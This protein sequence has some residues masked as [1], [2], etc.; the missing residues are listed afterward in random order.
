MAARG[1]EKAAIL[2]MSIGEQA[3]ADVLSFM[4]PKE[5][6]AIG[7][8]MAQMQNISRGQVA[9]ILNEFIT[10]LN[11]ETGLGLANDQYVRN[12][13]TKA[14]G[15]DKASSL[16]DRILHG[17]NTKG[18]ETLKWMD[19]RAVA[20]I[21]RQEHPQIIA[22]VLS[23]LESDQ[24]A[25]ILGLFPERDRVDILMRIASLESI[26]PAAMNELNNILEKQF[27]GKD[28]IMS[29]HVGGKKTAASILNFMD[30]SMEAETMDG[31]KERD[32]DLG[33]SIQDLMF[34]FDNL[35]DIDDRAIQTILR[36]VSSESLVLALKGADDRLKEKIF[37]NMSK[38]A[39]EMLRDDLEAKGPVRLS[40]VETA[41]K[42]ILAVARRLADAGEI[43]LGGAGAEEYV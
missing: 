39:S 4:D 32:A 22:I 23:Y 37:A 11:E 25:D 40:E 10:N 34:V 33:Q 26:Q 35:N 16:I 30:S 18:L 15:E 17:G 8:A 12:V 38:R 41:Q 27:T 28:N 9:D 21:V 24:S 31:I 29:S 7:T 2:L 43:A 6:Q 14:L 3:A 42:E 5:V 20:E 1:V 13:L 19:P 36:E